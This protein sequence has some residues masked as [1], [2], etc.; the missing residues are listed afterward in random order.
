MWQKCSKEK[1]LSTFDLQCPFD[2]FNHLFFAGHLARVKIGWTQPPSL[3]TTL[4]EKKGK[5]E[6]PEAVTYGITRYKITSQSRP[7]HVNITILSRESDLWHL[8]ASP[9]VH[10]VLLHE[11]AH[12]YFGLYACSASRI[13]AMITPNA[14]ISDLYPY[15]SNLGTSGHGPE[16]LRLTRALERAASEYLG[17]GEMDLSWRTSVYE[18]LLNVKEWRERVVGIRRFEIKEVDKYFGSVIADID[19]LLGSKA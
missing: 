5:K 13:R 10:G 15:L 4:A 17:L 14:D 2:A 7:R 8:P 1:I 18:E 9:T 11:M 19:A 6:V 12:A 16:W 3:P